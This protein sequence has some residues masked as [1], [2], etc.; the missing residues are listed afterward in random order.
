[1]HLL[2]NKSHE[3]RSFTGHLSSPAIWRARRAFQP[4]WGMDA[5]AGPRCTGSMPLIF[6]GWRWRRARQ[7][8]GITELPKRGCGS[9]T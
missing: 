6:T 3:R 5:T 8:P 1:V 4:M 9:E 2:K 7:E